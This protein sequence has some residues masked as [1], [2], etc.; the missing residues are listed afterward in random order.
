MTHG[1]AFKPLN[2]EQLSPEEQ[3]RRSS[4]FF[5]RMRTRRTVRDFDTRPV[6]FELIQNAIA[7]AATAPSGA[8]QQPWTFAV[9]SNPQLKRQIRLAAEAEERESYERRMSQEWLDA[10]APLGTNWMKPH[11]EDAPYL[12]IVFAQSHGIRK[13]PKT[14]EETTFKH[15]YVSESVGIAVGM[16]L[17]SLHL[18]GLATLTHTPSPM[19]FLG[20]LLKRPA[21]ERAMVLIPV[22]YPKPDATVPDISKK[23]LDEVMVIYD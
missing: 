17:A 9:V 6:P 19:G 2:F 18:A 14:G 4:E 7:T 12:I 5:E 23:S 20:Q 10:L 22:G 15:Y 3:H 16:L 8:N 13:D 1:Y 21:H 11:I